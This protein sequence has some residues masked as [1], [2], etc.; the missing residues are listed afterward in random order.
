MVVSWRDA[1]DD[2]A[3]DRVATY[4]TTSIDGG[5]TFGPQ[6]YANP[7]QQAV[8][9]I[10][11]AVN[12]IGPALDNESAGNPQL[13]PT[14]GFG[15]QMGLAVA[16]GQVFPVWAGNFNGPGSDL[17]SFWNGTGISTFPLNIWYQ[18]MS[19]AAGPRVIS[20]TMGPVID[21]NLSGSAVDVPQFI[22]APGSAN[23]SSITSVIPISGDPSLNIT[24]LEVTVSLVYPRDGDLTLTLIGPGGQ[25]VI[26]YK[27]PGDTG[28]SFDSTTFSD[29]ATESITAGTAPYTG[30]FQP[31]NPLSIFNGLQGVGNWSLV[32]SGGIGPNGGILQSWS[33]AINAI[34][35]KPTAFDITFDRP[36]DPQAVISAGAA[37]FT[38]AD[39]EVFY[40]DTTNGDASIPL[41]VTSVTPIAP[42]YYVTDPTQNG[43][44]GYTN[45]MITFDPDENAKGKPSG[46]TDYT[47]TYSYVILPDD[48]GGNTDAHRLADLVV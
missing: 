22:P 34:A 12:D 30:T 5:V 24:S 3:N 13:D 23:G 41:L 11:G 16:D 15:D 18:P 42:P 37:T 7:P 46:I 47:G 19:I 36:V 4:L 35:T 26:L 44:D 2:A 29:S 14:F 38:K 21:G 40:H 17:D 45:F 25:S 48:S 8:D 39:V 10:T 33:L 20:S 43:T 1:S 27:K 31:L 6:S 9:A 32:I 28:Q